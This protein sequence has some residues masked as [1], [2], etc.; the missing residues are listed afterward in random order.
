MRERNRWRINA[1]EY[2]KA[3][4]WLRAL[5]QPRTQAILVNAFR[6]L[7]GTPH[8]NIGRTDPHPI[9]VGV[10]RGS[11]RIGVNGTEHA[12]Q[13]GSVLWIPEHAQRLIPE[14]TESDRILDYR[15]HFAAVRRQRV[16]S[17]TRKPL[18]CEN[19]WEVLTL[20]RLLHDARHRPR[21]HADAH[22]RG[23]LLTM[24][25]EFLEPRAAA[26]LDRATFTPRQR[27][28]IADLL[29]SSLLRGPTVA[30]LA[31]GVGLSLDYFSRKFQSSYGVAPRT[32]IKQE[33]MRVIAELLV[34]TPLS[35]KEICHRFAIDKSHLIKQFRSVHGLSPTQYRRANA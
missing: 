4:D 13:A 14:R 15:I 23:L 29:V 16:L 30:G 21:V 1:P 28:R 3:A 10:E 33:R 31:R 35:V 22:V 24:V 25:S 2:L 11:V 7:P 12:L 19:A 32:Y 8:D 17:F 18:L 26:P 27:V 34:S 9:I 6:F 20:L 5:L